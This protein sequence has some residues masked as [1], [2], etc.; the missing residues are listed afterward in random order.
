MDLL[1]IVDA[2]T[3]QF[4]PFYCFQEANNGMP[5]KTPVDSQIEIG[6]LQPLQLTAHPSDT[7][8]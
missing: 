4:S 5:K 2:T 1:V 8:K 7:S 6:N 3:C